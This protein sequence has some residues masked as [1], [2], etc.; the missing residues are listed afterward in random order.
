VRCADAIEVA[1]MRPSMVL[2]RSKN[3]FEM[4]MDR[5]IEHC[6]EGQRSMEKRGLILRAAALLEQFG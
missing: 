3:P 4:I 5:P 2:R 6:F 1:L